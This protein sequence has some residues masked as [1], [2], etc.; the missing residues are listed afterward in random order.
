MKS[1]VSIVLVAVVGLGVSTFAAGDPRDALLRGPIREAR[2]DLIPWGPHLGFELEVSGDDARL[3]PLVAVIL[4]GEP[5]GDHK[6]SNKGAIR[7]FMEGGRIVGVGLLP[8][9]EPGAYA[10][11]LYD[12]EVR[13]GTFRVDRD[14]LLAA[15]GSLGVPL[16]EPAFRE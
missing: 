4:A 2:I 13:V 14:A 3:D 6:C 5:G 16:D 15:L 8:G 12:G 9:H 11:R 7:L 10:V 1:L